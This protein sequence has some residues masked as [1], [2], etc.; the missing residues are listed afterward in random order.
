MLG[1]CAGLFYGAIK[2]AW[3]PDPPKD[4]K[5]NIT[6]VIKKC[7]VRENRKYYCLETNDSDTSFITKRIFS[8]TNAKINVEEVTKRERKQT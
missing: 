7:S 3:Y 6:E 2:A 4:L 8:T 5:G 1:V